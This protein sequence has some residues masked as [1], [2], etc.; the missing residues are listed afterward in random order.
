MSADRLGI[1]GSYVSWVLH[2]GQFPTSVV[3]ADSSGSSGVLFGKT[4]F[5][6]AIFR[7]TRTTVVRLP[8]DHAGQ[9]QERWFIPVLATFQDIFVSKRRIHIVVNKS[10]RC[11]HATVIKEGL[12][13]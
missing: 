12:V 13:R 3:M 6:Q 11:H 2:E 4:S 1:V 9:A 5:Q 7:C 10:W 8:C